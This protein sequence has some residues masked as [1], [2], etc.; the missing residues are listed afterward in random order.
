MKGVS[1]RSHVSRKLCRVCYGNIAGQVLRQCAKK[2]LA[3]GLNDAGEI[4]PTRI[5]RS[6]LGRNREVGPMLSIVLPVPVILFDSR[7]PHPVRTMVVAV[8][9]QGVCK[10]VVPESALNICLRR[11]REDPR[12]IS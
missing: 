8:V 9:L 7:L 12:G 3:E 4:V 10:V 11:K 1:S 6:L 5:L 2:I